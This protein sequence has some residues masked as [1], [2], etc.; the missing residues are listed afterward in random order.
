MDHIRYDMVRFVLDG[1]QSCF[2]GNCES[3]EEEESFMEGKGCLV[4]CE[5]KEWIGGCLEEHLFDF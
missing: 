3:C 2:Q 1:I 4:I 5:D